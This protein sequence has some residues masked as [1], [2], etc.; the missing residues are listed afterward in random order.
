MADDLKKVKNAIITSIQM[1]GNMN[2]N[3]QQE[4]RSI[5]FSFHLPLRTIENMEEAAE[6][7]K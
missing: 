1:K 5:Y 3:Q 6:H 4:T 2:G 7:S